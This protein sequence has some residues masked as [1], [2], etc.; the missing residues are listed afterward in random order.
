MPPRIVTPGQMMKDLVP[1]DVRLPTEGESVL[2]WRL[3]LRRASPSELAP[4]LGDA[5]I[6]M[7]RD[8]AAAL[9]QELSRICVEVGQEGIRV[10][11]VAR[12]LRGAGYEIEAERWQAVADLERRHRRT[13]SSAGL[14]CPQRSVLTAVE[15][16]EEGVIAS[17]W[18]RVTLVGVS[19]LSGL[20]RRA[21]A[22]TVDV[23]ALIQAPPSESAGFDL[24]GCPD[25]GVWN[26]RLLDLEPARRITAESPAEMISLAV[27]SLPSELQSST[28][29]VGDQTLLP[30]IVDELELRRLAFHSPVG[31]AFA[32]SRPA[33]ALTLIS[34]FLRS[35]RLDD[36][37][38]V[39][40]C[41]DVE[42]FLT[43]AV[44]MPEATSEGP[45]EIDLDPISALDRY[46][47]D[48]LAVGL[49]DRPRTAT[50]KRLVAMAET[51]EA[52][53]GGSEQSGRVAV[54]ATVIAS[55]MVE[56][57]GNRELDLDVGVEA[58]LASS[59]ER[60]G[61][62]LTSLASVPEALDVEMPLSEVV[63]LVA[64]VAGGEPLPS[65]PTLPDGVEILGWLDL[66]IDD[67]SDVVV[68]GLNEG[69]I[70]R[71]VG[72]DILLPNGARRLLGLT[73]DAKR[74]ARDA[75][76][77]QGLV[78]SRSS[79]TLLASLIGSQDEPQLPSRLLLRREPADLPGALDGYFETVQPT[80]DTIPEGGPRDPSAAEPAIHSGKA[81]PGMPV[82]AF[83]DYLAC[84]YRFYLRRVAGLEV[85]RDR[86]REL[87]PGAFG[88]LAHEV[89][90]RFAT[91]EAARATDPQF[92][93][94][95]LT[96]HLDRVVSRRVAA[97]AGPAVRVQLAQLRHRL[98]RF[99]VWQAEQARQGWSICQELVEV[100]WQATL[101]V[102]GEDFLVRGRIDRVDRHPVHG[103]RVLDYKSSDSPRSP[104]Q[105]HQRSGEWIDLQ[106]PLYRL[107]AESHGQEAPATG[108][109]LLSK[110]QT[111]SELL[112]MSDWSAEEHEDA[113]RCAREVVRSV[114]AGRF[115]PPSEPPRY[116]DGL[117][118]V[119]GDGLARDLLLE[120]GPLFDRSGG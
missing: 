49:P 89:L 21:L 73:D 30:R 112:A 104:R 2:A 79:V 102:D 109:I 80:S 107:L 61:D 36:L 113:L 77:L 45:E 84:P 105:A 111:R 52:L 95:E 7:D 87:E 8:A 44:P 39:L 3:T 116:A 37:A 24:L 66:A 108:F 94:A 25:P 56:I 88:Q 110:K 6:S 63:G 93:E 29:G 19:E 10:A 76:H 71:R 50:E 118:L 32:D 55:A 26:D 38:A 114:R 9:A 47:S 92:L 120:Y 54:R 65:A 43:S 22:A 62:V 41:P 51:L 53:F 99:A 18:Q 27:E 103:T 100:D 96:R 69:T 58:E 4:L 13:L 57:F 17:P 48:C 70:P 98:A 68:L 78:R 106:L 115:W 16:L 59:L 35:R 1:P 31:R 12:R 82:T 5:R 14:A 15:A 101:S 46:V 97:D 81:L 91:S 60:L 33:R 42:R 90:Q 64:E 117:E 119:A 67:A 40:R 28:L 85:L 11:S 34:R 72:A 86:P 23:E 74:L 83:R 20:A 75:F